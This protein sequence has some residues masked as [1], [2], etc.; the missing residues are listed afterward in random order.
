MTVSFKPSRVGTR[1][2]RI[3]E[4]D[5]RMRLGGPAGKLLEGFEHLELSGRNSRNPATEW[6]PFYRKWKT[7]EIREYLTIS[8]T[9]IYLLPVEHIQPV[10][11][12]WDN[13][14]VHYGQT[15]GN[16]WSNLENLSQRGVF[17]VPSLDYPTYLMA[18]GANIQTF[19][20]CIEGQCDGVTI[21]IELEK[22]LEKRTLFID[23]ETIGWNGDNPLVPDVEGHSFFVLGGIPKEAIKEIRSHREGYIR[24]F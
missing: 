12:G 11:P 5:L 2:F 7:A 4:R 3:R 9:R 24:L 20:T 15:I 14:L 13:L 22:L 17:G 23:P 10:K 8:G 1:T 19:G 6:S 18:Q 21:F 16:G